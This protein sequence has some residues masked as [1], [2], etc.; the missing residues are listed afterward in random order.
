[1]IDNLQIYSK[2]KGLIKTY[3]GIEENIVDDYHKVSLFL[4]PFEF[5]PIELVKL[6]VL[7]K[8]S[9][10]LSF[11]EDDFLNYSFLS[12]DSIVSLVKRKLDKE[13]EKCSRGE[14][15]S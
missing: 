14:K 13:N 10:N 5:S 6:Y 11:S 3:F 2:V 7:I 12:I 15:C 9:F 1:M 4:K 8:Q